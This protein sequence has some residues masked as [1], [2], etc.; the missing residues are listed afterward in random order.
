MHWLILLAVGSMSINIRNS[1][2]IAFLLFCGF[3]I[4]AEAKI[5]DSF[6]V[7][8]S[9]KYASDFKYFEYVNPN[10]PKGGK[11]TL[12]AYGVFDNFNPFI[13]KGIAFSEAAELTLESLGFS[14]LD[15]KTS[16]YPLLAEKFELP[17]DKSF[18]GFI[19]NKNVCF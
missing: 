8:S 14:P 3:G 6:S 16:I 2:I 10:A 19:L 1:L 11:L 18:I 7:S 15:D 17:Q 9:P 5:V 4:K 13:F 12:P